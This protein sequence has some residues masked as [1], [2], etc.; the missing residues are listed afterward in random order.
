MLLGASAF[1][2]DE[3]NA[4][5]D[6]DGRYGLLD[7]LLEDVAAQARQVETQKESTAGTSIAG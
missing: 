3:M 4:K 2:Q 5:P 1:T 7:E 6:R